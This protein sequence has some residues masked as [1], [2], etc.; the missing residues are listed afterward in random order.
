M[1]IKVIKIFQF[2]FI[3]CPGHRLL[4]TTMLSGTALMDSILFF[5][6]VNDFFPQEQ[7]IEHLLSLNIYKISK[8]IVILSKIDLQ[9]FLTVVYFYLLL[10]T[11]LE[12]KNIKNK[13]FTNTFFVDVNLNFIL[14]EI[15]KSNN[16]IHREI[17]YSPLFI[18]IR[19]FNTKV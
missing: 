18:I 19:V 7:T 4:L 8:I 5:I 3:D 11:F 9:T 6:S 17:N 15:I 12:R 13:I 14:N 2:S 1:I 10:N 16:C